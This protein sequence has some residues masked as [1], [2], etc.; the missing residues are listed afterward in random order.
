VTRLEPT[1]AAIVMPLLRQVDTYLVPALRSAIDQTEPTD[2][3][4]VISPRT[5]P[6]NLAILERFTLESPRLRIVMRPEGAGFPGAINAGIRQVTSP[7]FGLLLSDDWLDPDAIEVTLPWDADI[8]SAGMNVYDA[9]G[10][11]FLPQVSGTA[12]A[13]RYASL[14]TIHKRA[15]YLRHFFLFRTDKVRSVG[16]LDETLGDTPGIDDYDFIWTLL[17]HGATV[18]LPGRSVYNCRDH[19]GERMTLRDPVA[20]GA[21]LLRILDKHGL[22]GP[23][24]DDI[25]RQHMQWYG[26]TL[27]ATRQALDEERARAR[28]EEAVTYPAPERESSAS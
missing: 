13:E 1:P 5:P 28:S 7:R 10:T 17:E 23:E 9:D 15:E 21:T 19:P 22:V 16:G 25:Y 8:V 3:I 20:K 14:T 2:V 6:S 4:V 24:R 18:A 27:Q 26:R 12:T 11:T